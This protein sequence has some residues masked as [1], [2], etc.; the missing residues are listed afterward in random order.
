MVDAANG[1]PGALGLQAIP[2]QHRDGICLADISDVAG[3]L[4]FRIILRLLDPV[5]GNSL[6]ALHAAAEAGS[7]RIAGR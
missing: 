3:H 5:R 6:V 4:V 2:F 1:P 7:R